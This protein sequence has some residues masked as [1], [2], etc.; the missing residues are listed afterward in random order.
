MSD[1][2]VDVIVPVYRGLDETRC[3]LESVLASTCNTPFELVVINDASPE[4]EVTEWLRAFAA[5]HSS[6]TLLENAENL[7]FVATV[8]RGM[9]LH[10]DRD[11]VLLNSDTEVA[12]DWLDRLYAAAYRDSRTASV[13][14]FSNNATVCS[15]P[16]FCEENP[17]PAGWDTASLDRVFAAANA[18][19]TAGLP[20]AVGFCMYIRRSCLEQV[21]L[22]D[23]ERFGKGYGEENE[24][25]MR[26]R[27]Q[28][29]RHVLAG[30]CFVR[31]AGGVSFGDGRNERQK[32]A[33]EVLNDLHPDYEGE[34]MRFVRAD[35]VRPLRLRADLARCAMSPRP[36]VLNVGHALGGGASRHIRDLCRTVR[37]EAE[38]LALEPA[39]DGE[40]RVRLFRPD[41]SE[42]L[43]LN[44]DPG[45]DL[46][47]L[48]Q[49]LQ[50]IG[51][52]H[53]HYHHLIGFPEAVRELPERL[54]VPYDVT[55]HDFYF[56]CPQKHLHDHDHR[57]C[58]EPDESGCNA[59]LQRR[60]APGNPSIETWRAKFR[61]FLEGAM[62]VLAP[63]QAVLER[64]R[65]HFPDV[66]YQL[67]PH[68]EPS[69]HDDAP[70]SPT[71]MADSESLRVLAIG[72]LG[73][74]KGADVLEE[75]ALL[76]RERTSPVSFTLL[77]FG[78]RPLRS[79]PRSS[80]VVTGAYSE[81]SLPGWLDR[82]RP[83]VVWFPAQVPE[84][85][86]FTLS[87]CFEA[88][89]PVVVSD[90]GALPER[91]QGR[92]WSW[93]CPWAL[94]ASQW[95]SLFEELREAHFRT[96]EQPPVPPGTVPAADFDYTR[97]YVAPMTSAR[98]T[99][100]AD[101]QAL[102]RE[103]E[104]AGRLPDGVVRRLRAFA[105]AAA[106]RL[107]RYDWLRGALRKLPMGMQ[108]RLR[109]WLLRA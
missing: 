37:G 19:E 73:E 79:H 50:A 55:L 51:I 101:W 102:Q 30:D 85:F 13:T 28:G 78:Y 69:R 97:D 7:G 99:G 57:Y 31:H 44:F 3:C 2:L 4:P 62:R 75:A 14:P 90:L 53:V 6:V 74:I 54:G 10:S 86:S 105:F 15:Y 88:G 72:A 9:E 18:G 34:V 107:H 35:P 68:P 83:H 67:A 17:M 52:D 46:D 27:A 48:L 84:T 96:G 63:S 23:V 70:V 20:T 109:R 92:P 108:G 16:R 5:D 59:C 56:Y 38:V 65:A 76:A 80:L 87:A 98:R 43:D 71:P 47:R 104:R 29:W 91:V 64:V 22:F 58:G 8:N 93:V 39:K 42:A 106:V 33:A 100:G 45:S 81:E 49:V 36:V 1:S 103:L 94:T 66:H 25:C 21:G 26:A 82:I 89:L 40:G 11:V 41:A 12:N 24:F 60:P 77:G 95:L 32:A 61:P